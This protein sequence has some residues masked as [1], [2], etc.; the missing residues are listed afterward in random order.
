MYIM[1]GKKKG[2]PK[3]G[4]RVAGTENKITGKARELFVQIM[5]GEVDHIQSALEAVRK[6][7][8]ADYLNVLSKF[9]PYFIPKQVD[10]TSK[11][12]SFLPP[13]ILLNGESNDSP[14]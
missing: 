7:N 8:P 10:I 13:T 3:S 4:G 12:E 9:F 14:K 11:G 2:S 1:K 5:E 6:K